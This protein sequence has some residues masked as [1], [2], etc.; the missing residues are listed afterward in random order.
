METQKNSNQA[1]NEIIFENRNKS[2]GAYALRQS[3]NTTVLKSLLTTAS[4][5]IFISLTAYYV[6]NKEDIIKIDDGNIV[7][8]YDFGHEVEMQ[9]P[10]EKIKEI[11]PKDNNDAPKSDSGQMTASDDKKDVNDQTN[12][13]RNTSSNPNPDGKK[14]S[15]STEFKEPVIVVKKPNN[16]LEKFPDVIPEFIGSMQQF[17]SRNLHYP[18]IAVENQAQGT[19]YISF[20]VEKDGSLSNF[21]IAKGNVGYGCEQEAIRVLKLMPQW[22]A[23][24]KKGEAVRYPCT[25]PIKFALK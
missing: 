17:I 16:E 7:E 1:L 5:F 25:L 3:E 8:N 18:T 6:S 23:G 14:L 21:E 11:P 15:D 9:P 20:V 24:I 12:E 13:D 4:L 2:Y 22:K 19:V 10:V